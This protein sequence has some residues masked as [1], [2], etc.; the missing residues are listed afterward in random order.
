MKASFFADDDDEHITISD[1]TTKRAV[2]KSVVT[3]DF[4]RFVRFYFRLVVICD[5]IA[6]R[7]NQQNFFNIPESFRFFAE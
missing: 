6:K 1:H 5:W 3:P 7:L 2:K 4:I